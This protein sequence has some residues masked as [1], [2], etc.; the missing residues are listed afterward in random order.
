MNGNCPVPEVITLGETMVMFSP[1]GQGP[2][3]YMHQFRKRIAGSESNVAV[4]LCRLGHT[5]GWISRVGRDEFGRFILKELRGEGVDVSHVV[6]DENAPTGIMFKELRS[7]RETRVTYYRKGSAASFMTEEDLDEE[8]ICKAKI[9]HITGITPALSPG[10]LRTLQTAVKMAKRCNIP[11]SF[12]PNIRLKLWSAEQAR[13]VILQILP[14][15]NM[16]MPGLEEA[17]LLLGTSGIQQ[18]IERLLEMG[19]QIVVLKTGSDGCWVADRNEMKHIPGFDPGT[20]V[21][22]IGAGDAFAAG[23]LAGILEELPLQQCA[24]MANAMGAMALT[25]PGDYEGLPD[26]QELDAFIRGQREITR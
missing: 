8:Y 17:E 3:R 23:F 24:V 13:E 10:C 20:V 11:V 15:C 5:A 7:G 4:G 18:S 14:D 6:E 12:D 16:V 2:L 9:L 26:R 22:P 19:I 1:E 25:T 21:D